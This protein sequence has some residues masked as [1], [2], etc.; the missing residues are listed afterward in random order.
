[1]SKSGMFRAFS[2]FAPH[3]SYGRSKSLIE[4]LP[5]WEEMTRKELP[6]IDETHGGNT[7]AAP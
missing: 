4:G 1:M 6:P 7:P 3:T 5:D 2:V